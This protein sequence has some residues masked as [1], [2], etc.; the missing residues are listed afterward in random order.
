ME[1]IHKC[2]LEEIRLKMTTLRR[3]TT[4]DG[5]TDGRTDKPKTIEL[6]ELIYGRGSQLGQV[7]RTIS[8]TF[9]PRVLREFH[10]KSEFN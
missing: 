5:R 7:T 8:T 9:S 1:A 3:V 6:R 10:M 4:T 2:N